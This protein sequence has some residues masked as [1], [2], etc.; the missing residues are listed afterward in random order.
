MS[1][2]VLFVGTYDIPEGG[3]DAFYNQARA[4]T[5]L[6]RE[7]EPR[8]IAV[9]HYLSDDQTEGTSIHLHPDADSFDFHMETASRLIE[10]GTHI[11]KV[12]RI[13]F[14]GKPNELMLEQL[15]KGFDVRVKTW[16]DGYSRLNNG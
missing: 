14:Y 9:G 5:D 15:S 6:I 4:M 7:H 12:T 8:V 3:L 16:A 1:E 2:M 10:R 11:L 13:E